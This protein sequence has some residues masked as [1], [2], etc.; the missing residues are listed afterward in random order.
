[1]IRKCW[2]EKFII[3]VT[4]FLPCQQSSTGTDRKT[5][6][7]IFKKIKNLKNYKKLT[8]VEWK[9]T[10]SHKLDRSNWRI[11]AILRLIFVAHR[12]SDLT[13]KFVT[14]PALY[15][16]RQGFE[17]STAFSLGFTWSA[18]VRYRPFQT[19]VFNE[20]SYKPK[21][22]IQY[23]YN[24]QWTFKN[25]FFFVFTWKVVAF[26]LALIFNFPSIRKDEAAF[27]GNK[28]PELDSAV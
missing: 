7:N 10:W 6:S 1:M 17:S 16:T 19:K 24:N 2:Y 27:E 13:L 4:L 8:S 18:L 12:S 5:G 15:L 28:T 25:S 26:S 22:N 23:E 11:P 9:E 14:S 20:S 21:C 3:S